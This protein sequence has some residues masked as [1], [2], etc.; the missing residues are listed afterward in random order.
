MLRYPDNINSYFTL[1]KNDLAQDYAIL[2]S[3]V[4]NYVHYLRGIF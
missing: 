2:P 1:K 3:F 4:Q